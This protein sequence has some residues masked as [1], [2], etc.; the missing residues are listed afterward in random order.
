MFPVLFL[1]QGFYHTILFCI[2]AAVHTSQHQVKSVSSRQA[3][4]TCHHRQT[5]VRR[6]HILCIILEIV[7]EG[8]DS[9]FVIFIQVGRCILTHH[10]LVIGEVVDFHSQHGM[11]QVIKDIAQLFPA[12]Q[13]CIPPV[14]SQVQGAV[15]FG[16]F[17]I[18]I[19]NLQGYRFRK[20]FLYLAACAVFP[21]DVVHHAHG[22]CKGAGRPL[23]FLFADNDLLACGKGLF[24]CLQFQFR[25]L[26]Y[27][28]SCIH[29]L[30]R[31]SRL[32]RDA[33]R[34]GSH[35]VRFIFC[36][37]S[38]AVHHSCGHIVVHVAFQGEF[39]FAAFQDNLCSCA[40][41]WCPVQVI[42]DMLCCFIFP[43]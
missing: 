3:Q 36:L 43:A 7:S 28:C 20:L 2:T 19:V 39:R 23:F 31:H 6:I 25:K 34:H 5:P 37:D 13:F 35:V 32:Y 21:R 42:A 29:C 40:E 24:L 17:K 27:R 18:F 30:F 26:H 38:V 12:F 9:Q 15:A 14:D 41:L 11:L 33:F 1:S 4:I 8:G 10:A 22:F 16:D